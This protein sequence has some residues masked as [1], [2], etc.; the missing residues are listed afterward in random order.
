MTKSLFLLLAILVVQAL[1]SPLSAQNVQSDGEDMRHPGWY[2]GIEGGVPFGISTFSSFGHDKTHFGWTGGLYGGYRFNPVLSAELTAKYGQMTLSAQDCCVEHNYWLGS[3]GVRYNA[4]VLGMDGWDYRDLQSRVNIGQ[5]GARLNVNL[6]GLFNKTKYSRWSLALSPHVYAVS[7]KSS[8]QTMN[9][10][11][12]R[13]EGNTQWHLGYGGDLQ[14]GYHI[15]RHLQLGIYS[16]VTALTGSMMDAVPE[17]LHKNNFVWESGVRLGFVFGKKKKK[18]VSEEPASVVYPEKTETVSEEPAPVVCPEK[19][20]APTV[21]EPRKEPV[22]IASAEEKKAI[23]FPDIYFDFNKKSIS[24]S[25]ESKLQQI[26][27]TLKE[28][29]EMKVTVKGWC[30]TKG[31]TS[32]NKRYSEARAQAVKAW[33]VEQGVSADRIE[34]IGMSSDF[35]EADS[36]KAR[37]VETTGNDNQ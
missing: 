5:Y 21:A 20:E 24:A 31:A 12:K 18:A 16:G 35:N 29:P 33:L 7:T 15:S 30:D 11:E 4:A 26:L 1:R 10:G 8:I 22:A 19:T 28:N 32:V 34:A 14:V 36:A 23:T 2:L 25:E 9:D 3:D 27:A 37:R 6:L 17:H 13:L